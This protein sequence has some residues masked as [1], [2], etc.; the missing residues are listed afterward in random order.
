MNTGGAYFFLSLTYTVI[1]SLPQSN[2]KADDSE[3][4]LVS[5]TVFILAGI[6]TTFYIWIFSSVHNLLISLAMRKQASKY[7]LYRNFRSVLSIS[8]VATCIWMLYGSVIN[9]NNGTGEDN[10]W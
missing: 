2:R 9:L 10:N 6:D 3:Y 5:L 1:S 7:I 8:F 4:D